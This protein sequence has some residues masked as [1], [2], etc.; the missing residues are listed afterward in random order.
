MV[1]HWQFGAPW[2]C[3]TWKV[4]FS[5]HFNV[6]VLQ[7]LHDAVQRKWHDKWQWFLHNDNVSSHIS[8]VVQQF[9]AEKNITQPP[10]FLDLAPSA[11]CLFPT[12]KRSF[13]G[14]MFHNHGGQQSNAMAEL[15]RFQ[16]KPSASASNNGRI[17]GVCAH[18]RGLG[19]R[20]CMS[21]HYSAIPQ[22]LVLSD[23]PSY[24]PVLWLQ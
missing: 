8:L 4:C 5:G 23:C 16:K 12:M 19:K 17:D 14:D 13:K 1:W 2:V 15:Q 11:F 21:C 24:L 18:V 10:Y 7:S 20:C 6:Q 3:I 9:L 22:F